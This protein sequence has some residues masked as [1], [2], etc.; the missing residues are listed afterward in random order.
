VGKRKVAQKWPSRHDGSISWRQ[1]LEVNMAHENRLPGEGTREP[2]ADL[3][4]GKS[5][6][7]MGEHDTSVPQSPKEAIKK[8]T[9]EAGH[10]K[11]VIGKARA[12]GRELDRDF[13]GEYERREDEAT[14]TGAP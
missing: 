4:S 9:S 13:G 12:I 5:T 11:G 7:T 3:A 6:S 10:E 1:Q 2:R 14:R 8:A